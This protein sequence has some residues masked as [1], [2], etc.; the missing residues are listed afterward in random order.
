M[1]YKTYYIFYIRATLETLYIAIARLSRCK[2]DLLPLAV[3]MA[4]A[5]AIYYILYAPYTYIYI[6]IYKY[7]YIIYYIDI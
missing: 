1:L 6:Y 4:V 5:G 7:F 3:A 2:R